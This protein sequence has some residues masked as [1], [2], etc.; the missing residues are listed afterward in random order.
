VAQ[1]TLTVLTP[2]DFHITLGAILDR[3]VE[4]VNRIFERHLL[5]DCAYDYPESHP[6]A[7]DAQPC[8]EKGIVHD[9]T[10]GQDFCAKHFREVSRGR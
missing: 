9:L 6:G 1:Q 2:Q 3:Y 4:S 7:C 10:I 5:S 8:C